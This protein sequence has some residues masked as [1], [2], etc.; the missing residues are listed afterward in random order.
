MG[1]CPI[2]LNL[3]LRPSLV[4]NDHLFSTALVVPV[5]LLPALVLSQAVV[6]T[7]SPPAHLPKQLAYPQSLQFC[8]DHTSEKAEQQACT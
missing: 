1:T 4:H 8:R 6:S 5:S 3:W 2:V 7:V